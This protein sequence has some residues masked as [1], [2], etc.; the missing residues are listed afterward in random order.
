MKIEQKMSKS[1]RLFQTIKDKKKTKG[2]KNIEKEI[3]KK[4]RAVTIQKKFL[5][6]IEDKRK[7][8]VKH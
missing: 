4:E 3:L 7:K 5:K 8:T 6:K 2:I 1:W